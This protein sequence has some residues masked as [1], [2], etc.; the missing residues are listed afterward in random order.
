MLVVKIGQALILLCC[1]I[2]AGWRSK[3]QDQEPTLRYLTELLIDALW[4]LEKVQ[5][6]TARFK[7][8]AVGELCCDLSEM[9][10]K[11]K[12]D[13][14]SICPDGSIDF[15]FT[16]ACFMQSSFNLPMPGL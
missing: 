7:N 8:L 16:Q 12:R 1:S 2:R 14:V 15:M 6:C 5:N 4:G 10:G 13:D 11:K 9:Y 3:D